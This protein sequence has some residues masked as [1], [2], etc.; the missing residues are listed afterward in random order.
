METEVSRSIEEQLSAFLDGELPD[1]ELQ[2]LV[3]RLERDGEY[4]ATLA[5]Y[6]LIGNILRKDPIQSAAEGFRAGITAAIE[7]ESDMAAPAVVESESRSWVVPLASAAVVAMVV[8]GLWGNRISD[9][10]TADDGGPVALVS[11][12]PDAG[13]TP[14]PVQTDRASRST[15]RSSNRVV[16][17]NDVGRVVAQR[18]S[19]LN[20]DRLTSYMVSHGERARSFQGPMAD[21]RIFVQQASFEE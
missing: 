19:T 6:S 1:E 17:P 7:K 11:T 18:R 16:V 3:R 10:A 20:R 4:R 14:L 15:A 13:V 12:L 2:L 5:R 9:P 21:S 8:V